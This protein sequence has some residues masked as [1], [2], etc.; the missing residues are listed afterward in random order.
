[1]KKRSFV[2]TGF[3]LLLVLTLVMGSMPRQVQAQAAQIYFTNFNTGYSGW[4]ASGLGRD[5]T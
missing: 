1:M 3:A 4:T 5:T 2:F